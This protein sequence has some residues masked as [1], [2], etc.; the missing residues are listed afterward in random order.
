MGRLDFQN[1]RCF[2]NGVVA[3]QSENP[4]FPDDH[5]PAYEIG[6][7]I[8]RSYLPFS[9]RNTGLAQGGMVLSISPSGTNTLHGDAFEHPAQQLL[10][11]EGR[12]H[13]GRRL[14]NFRRPLK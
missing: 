9:P 10:R 6:Q 8:P 1:E 12:C 2:F 3:N 7:R 11:C 4:G 13:R 14:P 5:Q